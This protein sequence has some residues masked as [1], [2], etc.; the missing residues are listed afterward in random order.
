M[1]IFLTIVGVLL[2]AWLLFESKP[3]L[4]NQDVADKL[5]ARHSCDF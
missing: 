5:N 3:D 1:T 2:L 4:D